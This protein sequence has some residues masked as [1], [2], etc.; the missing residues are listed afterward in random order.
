MSR[1]C[2]QQFRRKRKALHLQCTILRLARLFGLVLAV[3]VCPATGHDSE[4][5]Y[6]RVLGGL[7]AERYDAHVRSSSTPKRHFRPHACCN[8]ECQ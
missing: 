5:R 6:V 4:T 3:Q 7:S 1:R 8:T 2:D